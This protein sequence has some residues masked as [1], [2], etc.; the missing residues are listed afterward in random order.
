MN[1]KIDILF[2][3]WEGSWEDGAQ[4]WSP[5]E[6]AYDPDK[7]HRIKYTGEFRKTSAY[8]QSHPG[9][10][11]TPFIFQAGQS[12]AGKAF[13]ARHAEAIFA[14]GSSAEELAP[15]VKEVRAAA[16]KAGRDPYDVQIVPSCTPILGK[17]LEEAQ[18]KYRSYEKLADW[19]GGLATLSG[20]T[21]VDL[22]RYP[23]DKPFSFEGT[24]FDHT[25]HS[26]VEATQ[27]K[28][29]APLTPRQ[30]GM[31]WAFGGFGQKIVGTPEMVAD[32]IQE[33]IDIAD[34]DGFNLACKLTQQVFQEYPER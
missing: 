18:E 31:M 13:A 23:L 21:G 16:V 19:E 2:R 33:W 17:T 9:P 24:L 12:R 3:L 28:M 29:D 25:V 4:Q 14:S 26:M 34:I 6:G 10:Q 5:T 11:R 27:K 32:K 20:W 7:V 15:V 1:E 30:L 8:C 22:S